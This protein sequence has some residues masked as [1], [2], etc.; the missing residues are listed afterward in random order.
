M[1]LLTSLVVHAGYIGSLSLLQAVVQVVAT[2]KE[3]NPDLVYG[4]HW[5]Q[6][7][8]KLVRH[9]VWPM[10]HL[11]SSRLLLCVLVHSLGRKQSLTS[12]L[13]MLCC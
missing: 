10:M 3:A 13:H 7:H 5:A 6:F 11:E 9:R 4:E 2:L 12:V 1:L 8:W